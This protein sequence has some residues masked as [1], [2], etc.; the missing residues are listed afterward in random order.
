MMWVWHMHRAACPGQETREVGNYALGWG[1]QMIRTR[2]TILAI[3]GLRER[4]RKGREG[5]GREK[6]EERA[7]AKRGMVERGL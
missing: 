4:K 2:E 5:G 3:E 1:G 6:R 7:S